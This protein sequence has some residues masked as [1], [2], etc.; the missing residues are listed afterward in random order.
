[1]TGTAKKWID[2][3]GYGFVRPDDGTGDVFVHAKNICAHP[4]LSALATGQR[5]TFEIIETE[6][7][8]RGVDVCLRTP[9]NLTRS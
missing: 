1:M 4:P 9:Q 8:R 6:R 7:G 2:D 5:V 3:K